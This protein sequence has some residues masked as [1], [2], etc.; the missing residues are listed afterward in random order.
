[1]TMVYGKTPRRTSLLETGISR[2]LRSD[3]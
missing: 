1:M 3:L 2:P